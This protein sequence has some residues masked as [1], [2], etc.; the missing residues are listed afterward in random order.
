M[1]TPAGEEF[2]LL[3]PLNGIIT[4]NPDSVDDYIIVADFVSHVPMIKVIDTT[5]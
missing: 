4:I 5:V 2:A 3:N 1:Y